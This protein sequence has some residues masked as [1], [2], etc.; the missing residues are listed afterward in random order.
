MLTYD[1]A[2]HAKFLSKSR[3]QDAKQHLHGLTG[4]QNSKT[5]TAQSKADKHPTAHSSRVTVK[6]CFCS[7]KRGLSPKIRLLCFVLI[8]S[9]LS[10]HLGGWG[11]GIAQWLEHR[12]R[13]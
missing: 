13:D 11:A 8:N 12:T 1:K 9:V 10:N 7:Q 3:F 5:K 2:Q 6:C 4:H